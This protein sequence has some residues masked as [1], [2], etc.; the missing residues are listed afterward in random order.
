MN[1]LIQK[2]DGSINK[3]HHEAADSAD[4]EKRLK[5]L[6]KGIGDVTT[7]IF[8]RELRDVWNKADPK[9][10]P[11]VI[12]GARNLEIIKN[13]SPEKALAELKHFWKSNALK[14]KSFMNFETA[15]LRWG[16]DLRKKREI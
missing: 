1:N 4:L 8:L 14:G 13:E 3:L 7:S 9:P 11:L 15:L 5:E 2:Y 10:T 16:R 6:G 12:S